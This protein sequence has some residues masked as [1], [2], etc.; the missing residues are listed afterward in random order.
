MPPDLSKPYVTEEDRARDR[1][2]LLVYKS[3]IEVLTR[4]ADRPANS[5]SED[6]IRLFPGSVPGGPSEHPLSRLQ[7]WMTVYGDEINIIRD[8]RNRTVHSGI[9][10]DPELRG[11]AWLA[12]Q[13]IST[14]FDMQPSQVSPIWVQQVITRVA[15][16]AE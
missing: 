5:W 14:L 2:A 8:V 3:L 15:R 7:R 13:I 12:R 1:E 16:D 6:Q 4:L 10:T 11:T 9:V